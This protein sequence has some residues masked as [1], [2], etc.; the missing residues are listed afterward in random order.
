M[1]IEGYERKALRGAKKLLTS[2]RNISGAVCVY[3]LQDDES[4]IC[5]I[6]SQSNLSIINVP[7]YLYMQWTMRRGVVRFTS[8]E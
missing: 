6:L 3:H 8:C 7:G 1:D 2:S 4:V 5:N